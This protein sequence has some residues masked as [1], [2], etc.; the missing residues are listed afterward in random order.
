MRLDRR[1]IVILA[2]HALIGWALCGTII[3]VGFAVTSE[4]TALIAHAIGAPIIFAVITAGYVRFF[5]FTKPLA[6]AVTFLGTVVVMDLFVVSLL[7]NGNLEMFTSILGT[8]LPFAL[9]FGATYLVG[10][11]LRP[12][13]KIWFRA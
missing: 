3:A 2:G 13:P 11:L 1:E 6:T 9:I 7:I 10:Q 4:Q 5:N 12:R 8:W